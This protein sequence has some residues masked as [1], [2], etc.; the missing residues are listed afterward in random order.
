[1]HLD[2]HLL[3]CMPI[4]ATCTFSIDRHPPRITYGTLSDAENILKVFRSSQFLPIKQL[5]YR[6][7]EA[8]KMRWSV[9]TTVGDIVDS[10]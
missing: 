10:L 2:C 3:T 1:L 9:D 7:A 8:E 6:S 4:T 5:K